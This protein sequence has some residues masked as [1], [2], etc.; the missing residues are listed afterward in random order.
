MHSLFW[1]CY[2]CCCCCLCY[3]DFAISVFSGDWSSKWRKKRKINKTENDGFVVSLQW[4]QLNRGHPTFLTNHKTSSEQK[5]QHFFKQK[6]NHW[7]L[8]RSRWQKKKCWFFCSEVVFWL[9]KKVRWP[10]LSRFQCNNI[11][12]LRGTSRDQI[13]APVWCITTGSPSLQSTCVLFFVRHHV[14]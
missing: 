7:S 11:Y 14:S 8:S 12:D 1:R 5:N 2:C 4:N 10:R 6:I 3:R 13:V 9:T